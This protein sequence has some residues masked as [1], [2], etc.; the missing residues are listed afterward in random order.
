MKIGVIGLQGA[1]SEHILA[2]ERAMEALG[3]EGEAFWIRKGEDI[4]DLDGLIIPGGESTTIGKLMVESGLFQKVQDRADSG[5][6]VLGTCAG[7]ILLAKEGD[8]QVRRTGQPLLGL[9]DMQV[10]R[11]AFGRQRE[12]FEVDLKIPVFGENA[13]RAVFIRAPAV[14]RVWG[15][16]E[17]LAE[18]QDGIVATRQENLVAMAFHPE[19][20]P[21]TRAHEYFLKMCRE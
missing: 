14:K 9:M 18:Y 16:V 4:N 5:M 19:L 7:L 10:I 6:P 11:N 20:T 3:V 21:D 13:F 1:I 12:S 8:E 17:I 2:V 15:D